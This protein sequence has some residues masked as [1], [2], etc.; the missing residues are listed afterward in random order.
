[1]SD[2]LLSDAELSTSNLLRVTLETAYSLPDSWT[3]TSGPAPTYTVGMEVPLTAD[4]S[5]FMEF[6]TTEPA[7]V[8]S[9]ELVPSLLWVRTSALS[10]LI[11]RIGATEQNT[12]SP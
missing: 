3:L 7:I 10:S 9:D 6:H 5:C 8:S 1:M 12:L 2:S 4:V 11:M